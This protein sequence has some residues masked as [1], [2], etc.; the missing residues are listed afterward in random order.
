MGLFD[1][2]LKGLGFGD[3]EDARDETTQKI[4]EKPE[5]KNHAKFDL[6]KEEVPEIVL[7]TPLASITNSKEP[8]LAQ[9]TVMGK[10][11]SPRNHAD[12]EEIVESFRKRE[13]VTVNFAALSQREAERGL[14]FLSGAIYAMRGKVEKQS[15]NLFL[16]VPPLQ[17]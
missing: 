8:L 14:D 7:P 6:T 17:K 10:I 16:F 15:G 12:I 13:S 4:P 5:K 3:E 2:I 11:V 9:T 1:I